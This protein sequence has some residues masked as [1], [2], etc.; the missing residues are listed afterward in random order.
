MRP[1]LFAY[2][3]KGKKKLQN[4]AGKERQDKRTSKRQ[5]E[6]S[7]QGEGQ[8]AGKETKRKAKK[9]KNKK[10]GGKH[11]TSPKTAKHLTRTK[12][13]QS[14]QRPQPIQIYIRTPKR[15]KNPLKIANKGIFK[16]N[17]SGTKQQSDQKAGNAPPEDQ[18][19]PPAGPKASKPRPPLDQ[20]TRQKAGKPTTSAPVF[21]P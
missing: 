10:N 14:T 16:P 1:F 12:A 8:K 19:Q 7:R 11:A 18:S 13:P 6:Q 20:W 17:T 2:S 4:K 5:P 15:A 21:L 3:P 9:R